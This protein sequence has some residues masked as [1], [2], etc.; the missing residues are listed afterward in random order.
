[1]RFDGPDGDPLLGAGVDDLDGTAGK[2]ALTLERQPRVCA[3]GRRQLYPL[4]EEQ[5][6]HDQAEFVER[7][8]KPEGFDRARA[9]NE[10]TSP[11]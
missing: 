8:E 4:A 3:D 5:R 6:Q 11:P 7:S 1:M 10:C 9:S 2:G